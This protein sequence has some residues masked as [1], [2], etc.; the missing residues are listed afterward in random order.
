M[1]TL[2]KTKEETLIILKWTGIALGIL[3][4]IF[5]AVRLLV[6]TKG[7]FAPTP[8][9]S[10][11]FGKLPTIPF[12]EQKQENISYTLDTLTG[13]LPNFPDR[14]K[15]YKIAIDPPTL[16]GLDKTRKKVLAIGFNSDGTRLSEET[17]QWVDQIESLQ[18]KVIMNIFS[19]DFTLSSSYLVAPSSLV[20]SGQDEVDNSPKVAKDFL[21]QM[22]I[23]PKDIDEEKT[24]VTT[25]S[26]AGSL[27]T[28]TSKISDTKIVKV[29]FFQND[30]NKLPIYY[31]K[32]PSSTMTFLVGKG[33]NGLIV[34][35]ARFFHKNIS[36][37]NSDYYIKTASEAFEELKAGKGYIAN[38]PDNTVEFSIKKVF[39]A[40]YMGAEQQEYMMPVVVFEGSNDF[41]AYVSAVKDE[42]ISN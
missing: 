10:A 42:W 13:F 14:E 26:T 39:L 22:S 33:K 38:K 7:L 31:D 40:Y 23:L 32:A 2:N 30:Q 5:L 4:F 6:F 36:E 29:D 17:Y 37:T 15:I 11:S 34:V 1:P 21:S 9:P 12:P 27:L 28:Q 20:F 3:F 8:P 35:G 18:R 24:K 41:V 16:L 19:S 25:Y